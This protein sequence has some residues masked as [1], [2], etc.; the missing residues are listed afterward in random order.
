MM[1]KNLDTGLVRTFVTVTTHGS[2]TAAADTLGRTQGAISQQIQRLEDAFGRRLFVREKSGMQ[3]TEDGRKFLTLAKTFLQQNDDIIRQMSLGPVKGN[4]RLGM[5]YDLV[6]SFL[7]KILKRFR[8]AFPGVSVDLFCDASPDLLKDVKAGR[9]DIAIIEEPMH[10]ATGETLWLERLLWIG[11]N[12]G[13]AYRDRPLPLSVVDRNCVFRPAIIEGLD[14]AGIEWHC[15]FENGNIDATMAAVR[16]DL[17]VSASLS[18]MVQQG[19]TVLL[20]DSG[21]PPLPSFAVTL[22]VSPKAES[23]GISELTAY[24]RRESERQTGIQ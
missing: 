22:H 17:A 3:L 24:L 8:E 16:A 23:P 15:V 19:V 11:A 9:L 13:A 12:D 18:S 5:P 6:Q 4:V 20:E 10:D 14:H 2:V 7:P 1:H 21:L